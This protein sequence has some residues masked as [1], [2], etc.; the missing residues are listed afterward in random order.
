MKAVIAVFVFACLGLTSAAWG[1]APT[2]S[3]PAHGIP[4]YLDPKTGT[5]KPLILL[6]DLGGPAA[7]APT[8]G[9]LVFTFTVTISSTTL[10]TAA[11]SCTL[12][13]YV[14]G[15]TDNYIES[16]A[17]AATGTG[18]SRTCTVTL[19]YSWILTTA[20]TDTISLSYDVEAINTTSGAYRDSAHSP[21]AIKVPATGTTTTETYAVTL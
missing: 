3:R 1:Q 12:E 6:E 11:V 15:A 2:P 14:I 7:T 16:A 9:K 10:T 17:A 21:A 8:T 18:A 4:G 5:F 20:A 19:P 13:A